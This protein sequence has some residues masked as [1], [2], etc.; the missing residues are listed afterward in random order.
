VSNEL[1]EDK[2]ALAN[3]LGDVEQHVTVRERER[4]ELRLWTYGYNF[5]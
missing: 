3:E 1:G 4:D 5:G 2:F